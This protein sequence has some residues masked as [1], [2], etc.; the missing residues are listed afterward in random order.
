MEERDIIDRELQRRFRD[1]EITPRADMWDAI[2]KSLDDKTRRN[3]TISLRRKIVAAV[4]TS[5]AI[6]VLAAMLLTEKRDEVTS[7]EFKELLLSEVKANRLA[8]PVSGDMK[9]ENI[10]V[11]S[12]INYRPE[13][14]EVVSETETIEKEVEKSQTKSAN[15]E[16]EKPQ[17][18][19]TNRKIESYKTTGYIASASPATTTPIKKLQ[20][21]QKKDIK[22]NISGGI[23]SISNDNIKYSSIEYSQMQVIAL[24]GGNIQD[25]KYYDATLHSTTTGERDW[26]HNR[27][28]TFSVTGVKMLN[29]WLGLESGISYTFLS[30][31]SKGTDALMPDIK[32]H[33]DYIGVPVN[34]YLQMLSSDK[35]ELYGKIGALVDKCIS[36]ETVSTLNNVSSRERIETKGVQLSGQLQLGA[37]Y[38]ITK[39]ISLYIEPTLAYY[40]DSNQPRSFRT[41]NKYGFSAVA[42]IRFRL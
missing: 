31:S 12:M 18:K 3:K 36:A 8:I 9:V 22:I 10:I 26:E 1:K 13:F 19:S 11:T 16:I 32:N 35:I 42:G 21:K 7:Y 15:R 25:K 40:A 28:L 27:P 37:S 5:A 39:L 30:S 38:K 14:N 29:R 24:N 33:Y 2:E 34:L 6:F 4:A 20:Q 41:D 23:S 17:T